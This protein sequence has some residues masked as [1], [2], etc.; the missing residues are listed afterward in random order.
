[1][2]LASYMKLSGK[3]ETEIAQAAG[4]SQVTI[5]RLKRGKR[6][7]TISLLQRICEATDWAVTLND[8]APSE[9]KDAPK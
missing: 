2:K 1:M 9:H 6:N 3:T 4:T 7:A 5:N 8:F